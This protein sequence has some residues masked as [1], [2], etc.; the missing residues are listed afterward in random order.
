MVAMGVPRR[1][2]EAI[3][4][5]TTKESGR[6]LSRALQGKDNKPTRI[7][8]ASRM[9]TRNEFPRREKR[10]RSLVEEPKTEHD[11]LV[12]LPYFILWFGTTEFLSED[13]GKMV[14]CVWTTYLFVKLASRKMFRNW[15]C[16]MHQTPI[17][18]EY[19]RNQEWRA[20]PSDD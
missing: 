19:R 7:F 9:A 13:S 16:Y 17:R 11:Y 2:W 4:L 14:W 10:K 20:T 5:M 15:L 3:N 6:V 18:T 1:C 12:L 8:F